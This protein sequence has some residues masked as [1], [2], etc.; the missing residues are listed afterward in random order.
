MSVAGGW[1]GYS[2]GGSIYQN[3]ESNT[4]TNSITLNS[5]HNK[6]LIFIAGSNTGMN[7]VTTVDINGVS[8]SVT[9]MGAM[10]DG[11]Y[12]VYAAIEINNNLDTTITIT[13]PVACYNYVSI[14]GLD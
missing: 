8:Y 5:A 13:F 6:L 1:V 7:N 4:A 9:N 12:S 10:Y 2:S 11:V 14:I 3:A